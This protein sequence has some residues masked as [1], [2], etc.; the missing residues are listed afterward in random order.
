MV[1]AKCERKNKFKKNEVIRSC[2]ETAEESVIE[3]SVKLTR[4]FNLVNFEG[5]KQTNAGSGDVDLFC[6]F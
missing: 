3:K 1:S 4:D 6:F 5:L 2:V